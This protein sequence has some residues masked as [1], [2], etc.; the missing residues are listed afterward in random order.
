MVAVC[1]VLASDIIASGDDL[2]VTLSHGGSLA[3]INLVAEKGRN[4]RSFLG[5]PY[6]KPPVGS[7]RFK[8]S[9]SIY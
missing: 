1:L 6:A 4:I 8:V 5:I 9:Y 2:L 3:G 7:L